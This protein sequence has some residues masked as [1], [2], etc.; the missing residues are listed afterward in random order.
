MLYF[1]L[2]SVRAFIRTYALDWVFLWFSIGNILMDLTFRSYI[3]HAVCLDVFQNSAVCNS[4]VH[5]ATLEQNVQITSAQYLIYYKIVTYAPSVIFGLYCGIISD[6]YSRKIPLLLPS[7][8]DTLA[9]VIYIATTT[10]DIEKAKYL[11]VGAA[12]NGL[13]GGTCVMGSAIYGYVSDITEPSKR[14]TRFGILVSVQFIGQV[15]GSLLSGLLQEWFSVSVNYLVSSAI[16]TIVFLS[17]VILLKET[18]SGIS[19]IKSSSQPGMSG[20]LSILDSGKI[21]VKKRES[22]SRCVLILVF[23]S[24]LLDVEYLLTERDI[25]LL[26]V[27]SKPL[28]WPSSWYG[29]L[30]CVDNAVTWFGLLTLLPLLSGK[31]GFSDEAVI[32][33]GLSL[34]IVRLVLFGFCTQSWMVYTLTILGSFGQISTA[35]MRSKMIKIVNPDEVG[36]ISSF[37]SVFGTLFKLCISS[38]YV[39]MYS[40]TFL[41][42]Q[43]IVYIIRAAV[44]IFIVCLYVSA[45]LKESKDETEDSK[46]CNDIGS[47]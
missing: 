10:L 46:Q 7:F 33:T 24:L 23:I 22:N 17:V 15:F 30:F 39:R 5:H 36:Q 21:L 45:F 9:C 38:V 6:K 8:G 47:E 41:V 16:Q 44:Y 20:I 14:T 35:A 29:Y 43:S 42:H 28:S 25:T 18:T 12:T 13:F 4:V 34:R 19:N 40:A 3:S 27:Q 11:I 31:L 2:E 32:I 1:K 26:F 37:V